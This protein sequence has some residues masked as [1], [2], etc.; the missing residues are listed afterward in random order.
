MEN[1]HPLNFHWMGSRK[2]MHD[3]VVVLLNVSSVFIYFLFVYTS[4]TLLKNLFVFFVFFA[5]TNLT[6]EFSR[7]FSTKRIV[8]YIVLFVE[9]CAGFNVCYIVF[10]SVEIFQM[11]NLWRM[12]IDVVVWIA[13]WFLCINK[14]YKVYT[15]F[16]SSRCSLA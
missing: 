2:V 8:F 16:T 15:V 3:S 11:E 5:S 9:A 4:L 6:S 7:W 10:F 13:G 14:I 1:F 12:M